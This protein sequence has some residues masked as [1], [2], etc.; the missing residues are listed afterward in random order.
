MPCLP[1]FTILYY[2]VRTVSE[3][4]KIRIADI[5][6]CRTRLGN[7]ADYAMAVRKSFRALV[8]LWTGSPSGRYSMAT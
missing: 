2:L 4:S 5:R 1:G 8:R 3:L 6:A 7:I